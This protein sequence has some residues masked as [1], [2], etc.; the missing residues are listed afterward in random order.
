MLNK[1]FTVKQTYVIALEYAL[2]FE[3][4]IDR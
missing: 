4:K 1:G 3:E 2:K